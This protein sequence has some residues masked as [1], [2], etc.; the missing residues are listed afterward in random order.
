MALIGAALFGGGLFWG[1]ITAERPRIVIPASRL[2]LVRQ[3][4][5]Q[6]HGRPPAREEWAGAVDALVDQEVLYQY[7]VRLKMYEEPAAQRRLAQ[8]ASFVETTPHEARPDSELAAQAIK[9]GLH[10]SD[11]VVR[12]I[13]ADGARRLIRAVVL[14]RRANPAMVEEY[15]AANPEP[16]RRPARMRITHVSVSGFKSPDSAKARATDLLARLQRERLSPEQGAALGD[17]PFVP[18]KLPL[19]TSKDLQTRFGIAFEQALEAS[20][21]E[22]WSGPFPSR[23]GYHLVWIHDRKPAYVPPLEEIRPLVEQRFLQKV[24]DEWLAL[25]LQQL[26]AEFDI[27]VPEPR[28]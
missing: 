6:D 12:R 18:S 22:A 3:T 28:R 20:P 23:Y 14:T 2:D 26:R 19:L 1:G 4:F 5:L 9:L 27:V 17:E 16:F 15:L 8:I 25:R 13:L 10:E 11:L 24:A 21:A 7:A